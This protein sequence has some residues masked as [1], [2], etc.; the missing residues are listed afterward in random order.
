MATVIK[1]AG[2]MVNPVKA[3]P[4]ARNENNIAQINGNFFI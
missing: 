4:T 1:T 3:K 2:V